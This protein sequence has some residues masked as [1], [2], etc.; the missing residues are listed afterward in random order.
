MRAFPI[1]TKGSKDLPEGKRLHLLVAIA[2]G[3]GVISVKEYEKMTRN[4]FSLYTKKIFRKRFCLI[5][6]L[7]NKIFVMDN[8]PCQNSTKTKATLKKLRVTMQPIPPTSP[9]LNPIENAFHVVRRQM[10][11]HMKENMIEQE[12]WDEFVTRIKQNIYST[13]K[14]KRIKEFKNVVENKGRRIKY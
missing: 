11:I 12:S 13:P 10:C 9:D 3:K 8:E 7:K 5:L 4:Y 2:Y 1:T 14:L 6:K